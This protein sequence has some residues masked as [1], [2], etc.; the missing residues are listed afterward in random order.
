MRLSA[1]DLPRAPLAPSYTRSLRVC[2]ESLSQ[3]A[4][5]RRSR[6]ADAAYRNAS[7]EAIV[8]STS[9][10]RRRLRL[11]HAKK[12]STTHRRAWT[13]N[14]TWPSSLR[15]ISTPMVLAAYPS[16]QCHVA[17][18][19]GERCLPRGLPVPRQQFSE[20]ICRVHHPVAAFA[21]MRPRRVSLG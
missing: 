19:S 2:L 18:S 10:A 15:T 1:H 12:R 9:L 11:I 14:P 3:R 4:S 17:R 13:A 5:L 6:I 8:A 20:L 21:S 16:G 7:A